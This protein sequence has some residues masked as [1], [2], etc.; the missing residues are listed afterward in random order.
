MSAGPDHT[1]AHLGVS[2]SLVARR[3]FSCH[4]GPLAATRPQPGCS[5]E[6]LSERKRLLLSRH[7]L[8]GSLKTL[9]ACLLPDA[10]QATLTLKCLLPLQSPW[11]MPCGWA[12][13]RGHISRKASWISPLSQPFSCPSM[14]PLSS[15]DEPSRAEKGVS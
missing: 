15:A 14:I 9:C 11:S 4:S 12:H 6:A 2:N 1:A 5:T 8:Q 3:F 13:L 10:G 7:G